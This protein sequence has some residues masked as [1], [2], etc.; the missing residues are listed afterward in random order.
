M[1]LAPMSDSADLPAAL[2]AWAPLLPVGVHWSDVVEELAAGEGADWTD[3][4]VLAD[5]VVVV[6]GEVALTVDGP[7]T[8]LRRLR[9]VDGDVLGAAD[10]IGE[11]AAASAPEL[12]GLRLI[13]R[14]APGTRVLV[15][16]QRRAMFEGDLAPLMDALR[17]ASLVTVER[18]ALARLLARQPQLSAAPPE[19]RHEL[20]R[21]AR[22]VVLE[23]EQPLDPDVLGAGDMAV[24][25]AGRMVD[26][27]GHADAVG[28]HGVLTR[29]G[30]E[31]W[32]AI[33]H[34]LLLVLPAD[35][36]AR[37]RD[38]A[39]RATAEDSAFGILHGTSLWRRIPADV[40]AR[41]LFVR[42]EVAAGEVLGTLSPGGWVA[43]SGGMSLFLVI[44]GEIELERSHL[45]EAQ[46]S[47][48]VRRGGFVGGAGWLVPAIELIRAPELLEVGL[49]L[50]AVGP[51]VVLEAPA[52]AELR[53][54][55]YLAVERLVRELLVREA[56]REEVGLALVRTGL[57]EGVIP[58]VVDQLV[59]RGA[60]VRVPRGTRLSPPRDEFFVFLRGELVRH[61]GPEDRRRLYSPVPMDVLGLTEFAEGWDPVGTWEAESTCW[62]LR[63]RR[64]ELEDLRPVRQLLEHRARRDG[65]GFDKAG[66]AEIVLLHGPE[67]RVGVQAAF[68]DLLA[69]A[70]AED[71]RDPVLVVQLPV[72][73]TPD[74]VVVEEQTADQPARVRLPVPDD[75]PVAALT[76]HLRRWNQAFAWIVLVPV[77]REAVA[78]SRALAPLVERLVML[79]RD[80]ARPVDLPVTV[81]TTV[82]VS[83]VLPDNPWVDRLLS[84]APSPVHPGFPDGAVRLRLSELAAGL[85]LLGGARMRLQDLEPDDR[86]RIRRWSRA[87]TD[88]RV[89]LALGGGGAWGFVHVAIIQELHRRGIP[90]DMISG[91]S[92][93]AVV[94]ALYA[95][96][97]LKGL[98]L[99]TAAGPMMSRTMPLNYVSTRALE[100]VIEGLVQAAVPLRG[101]DPIDVPWEKRAMNMD[102]AGR[103]MLQAWVAAK[104]SVRRGIKA[105]APLRVHLE[106]LEVPFFPVATD[107]DTGSE[108]VLEF[109][110]VAQG[111][112]A[113]GSFPGIF[114]A[115]PHPRDGRPLV[116]GGIASNVPDRVLGREGAAL[117]VASNPVPPPQRSAHR[118]SVVDRLP[119]VR[120]LPQGVRSIYIMMHSMGLKDHR[121]VGA[122]YNSP[123]VE[124]GIT[125]VSRAREIVAHTYRQ[126]E[127]RDAIH[128]AQQSWR[129]LSRP[130]ESTGVVAPVVRDARQADVSTSGFALL[131]P[132]GLDR[133]SAIYKALAPLLELRRAEAERRGTGRYVELLGSKD[134]LRPGESAA[135]FLARI[136]ATLGE[137]DPQKLPYHV[138][139][140]ASPDDVPLD[141]QVAL[142]GD[143]AVGRVWFEQP[144]D[145]ARYA[146]AVVRSEQASVRHRPRLALASCDGGTPWDRAVDEHLLSP[147]QTR[148]PSAAGSWTVTRERVEVDGNPEAAVARMQRLFQGPEAPDMLLLGSQ[149]HGFPRPAPGAPPPG[150]ERVGRIRVGRELALGPERLDPAERVGPSIVVHYGGFT[151]GWSERGSYAFSD[152][153]PG[154][155]RPPGDHLCPDSQALLSWQAGGAL[156]VLGKLD[157]AWIARTLR[158]ESGEPQAIAGLLAR[159]MEG[160][161]I[162]AAGHALA[163]YARVESGLLRNLEEASQPVD[164]DALEVQR[165]TALNAR[166]W[167]LLG[168]PAVRLR[169]R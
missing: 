56:C 52:P 49:R 157:L 130:R 144:D 94:G 136:G 33:E 59:D 123:P 22:M 76:P 6:D 164:A 75:D 36:L 102:E 100:W 151:G 118:R 40:D 133:R 82:L 107:L 131:M 44:S 47:R 19:A 70:V 154:W 83:A 3:V 95:C 129:R 85:E 78:L 38:I 97:G 11:L 103:V 39:A 132:Q 122:V 73:P 138:L 166:G 105:G 90:I 93:G 42:R 98:E 158:P 79:T 71:F 128:Q 34:T 134:G 62:M 72:G 153:A 86:E 74:Q 13:A 127:F 61:P 113:S 84:D 156:A 15:L 114:S 159:L 160:R 87:L 142:D 121:V 117:V 26:D 139:L 50:R 124:H 54:P 64:A 106:D 89:G 115:T 101:N 57:F 55:T 23:A 110:P 167:V 88:R 66:G 30:G 63:F 2:A 12:Q 27:T 150:F 28:R 21:T 43:G 80:P 96:G 126:D 48:V 168:D 163:E 149:T 108:V 109:G 162:G 152:L 32:A 46:G 69:Q 165:I 4:D 60:L 145:F 5:P 119:V 10:L 147:I 135:A 31:R 29:D 20:V 16:P 53:G 37:L 116:D 45:G 9:L 58:A 91:C 65:V 8:S 148:L 137:V 41:A 146:R 14:A 141:F 24:V 77:E 81:D 112:R 17:D 104:H 169:T 18:P 68:A 143:Y 51:A 92:F 111:V 140:V 125:D 99:L 67:Y 161:T 155:T 35:G 1:P 25:V 7:L 120:R